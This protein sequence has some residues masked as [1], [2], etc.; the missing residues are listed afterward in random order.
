MHVGILGGT[1]PAGCALGSR[2]AAA[3]YRVTIG[4]RTKGRAEGVA[5]GIV[6][7]WPGLDLAVDGME[8]AGAAEADVVVLA[9]P[10]EGAIGTLVPLREELA[11]KVVVSMVSA[12]V[13]MGREVQA[14]N[15]PRGSVAATVQAALPESQ[16]TAAFHHL[17]A[18]DLRDLRRVLDADVLVCGDDRQA[19]DC[20]MA[21]ADS[22]E[23]LRP[24]DAGRLVQAQA[25]EAFTAVCIAINIRYKARTYVRMGGI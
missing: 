6:E 12:L 22:I 10:W 8:N 20:T 21:L 5:A 14:V 16:V 17:P 23:G 19:K 13:R 15:L 4:S 24:L 1:G 11:D 25:I 3:G 18:G 2:L 7:A 9:T